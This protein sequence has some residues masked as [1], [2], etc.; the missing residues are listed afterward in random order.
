MLLSQI[1]RIL[2]RA[3]DILIRFAYQ[4]LRLIADHSRHMIYALIFS[5]ILMGDFLIPPLPF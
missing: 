3:L 4:G 2:K 1:V 5:T